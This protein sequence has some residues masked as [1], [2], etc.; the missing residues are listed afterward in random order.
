MRR[1]FGYVSKLTGS[2]G[3]SEILKAKETRTVELENDIPFYCKIS[4]VGQK[5]PIRI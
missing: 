2:V 4:T 5:P 3:H 1:N